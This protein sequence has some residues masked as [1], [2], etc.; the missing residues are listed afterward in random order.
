[1]AAKGW[2][3]TARRQVMGQK[4]RSQRGQESLSSEAEEYTMLGTATK[5]RLVWKN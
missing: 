3:D 2:P 1:M 5:Q 4:M